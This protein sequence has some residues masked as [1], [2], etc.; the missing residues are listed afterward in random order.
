[1]SE[2][3][4][5]PENSR[6][7]MAGVAPRRRWDRIRNGWFASPQA[8]TLGLGKKDSRKPYIVPVTFIQMINFS[9]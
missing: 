2:D 1:M 4:E 6:V 3:A 9:W 7:A 5:R 8:A